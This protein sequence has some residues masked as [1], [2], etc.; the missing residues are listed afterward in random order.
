MSPIACL[1]ILCIFY[2]TIP[3]APATLRI[4]T[5]IESFKHSIWADYSKIV[6]V[7]HGVGV[8]LLRLGR[9][10]NSQLL[11]LIPGVECSKNRAQAV[12]SALQPILRQP[13]PRV[14]SLQHKDLNWLC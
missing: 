11:E 8:R 13:A 12:M 1:W 2:S 10:W 3:P 14:S 9:N 7:Q 6:V 4:P 5:C